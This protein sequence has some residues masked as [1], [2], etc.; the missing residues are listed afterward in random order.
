MIPLFAKQL[1]ISNSVFRKVNQQEISQHN[2]IHSYSSA[3]IYITNFVDC[4]SEQ[5]TKTLI[6]HDE[7]NSIDEGTF[8]Q[9]V[10]IKL[11]ETID[12]CKLNFI[13]YRAAEKRSERRRLLRKTNKE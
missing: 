6:V 9:D 12:K 3:T 7:R 10:A 2:T 13:P 4:Y 8:G 1:V 5:K 11:K